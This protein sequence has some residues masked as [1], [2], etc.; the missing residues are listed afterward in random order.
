VLLLLVFVV[1]AVV[2]A[3]DAGVDSCWIPVRGF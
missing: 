3:V 2:D 1:V